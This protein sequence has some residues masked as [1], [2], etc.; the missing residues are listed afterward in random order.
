MFAKIYRQI[1]E[2]SIAS[3]PEVR[4]VFMD[5]LVLADSSGVVD[6]THNAIARIAN[7]PEERIVHCITELMKS[8]LAGRSGKANG[9]RLV[10]IDPGQRAW[11]WRIVNYKH[12]RG[13]RDEES[14]RSYFRGTRKRAY[15]YYAVSDGRVRIALGANPWARVTKLKTI[16]P[17]IELAAKEVGNADLKRR[18]QGEFAGD[19][20]DK[21]WFKL[22]GKL[23]DH[24]AAVAVANRGVARVAKR[25]ARVYL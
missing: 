1:F 12:Y 25:V 4:H 2:S 17:D 11:G 23:Q 10:L 7:V 6:A 24:I 16:Y 18:R 9:A 22:S 5:L 20:I 14:R 8:D 21:D 19:R 15:V 3:D 13:I